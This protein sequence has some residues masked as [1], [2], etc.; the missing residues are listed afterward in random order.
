M[1][2]LWVDRN[3]KLA[4]V[5]EFSTVKNV[6]LHYYITASIV[7]EG[8]KKNW[9][10]FKKNYEENTKNFSKQKFSDHSKKE[11]IK[12][13]SDYPSETILIGLKGAMMTFFTPGTGQYSRLFNITKNKDFAN[14][15]F[16]SWGLLWLFTV[17]FFA[18]YGFFKI[19]KDQVV[20][21]LILMFFYL[22]IVSSGPQS[23]SRFRIPFIPIIVIF[24][25]YGLD[26]F[27]NNIKNKKIFIKE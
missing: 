16:I 2:Q 19:K 22:L 24:A 15:L 5:K 18:T 12:A 23:Y 14:A 7:A 6:N 25:S 27:L 9:L 1:T 20:M 13:I 4:N 11:F 10:E 21:V 8:Q 26:C 17:Y 3:L